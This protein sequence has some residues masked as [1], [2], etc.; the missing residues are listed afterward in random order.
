MG[1]TTTCTP[2]PI[3]NKDEAAELFSVCQKTIDNYRKLGMP[4]LKAVTMIR[5]DREAILNWY[6][7]RFGVGHTQ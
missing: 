1:E 3:I 4:Y 6:R 2:K 5:F 7:K